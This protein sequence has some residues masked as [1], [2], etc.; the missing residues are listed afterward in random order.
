M[1]RPRK[2][3]ILRGKQRYVRKS[4]MEEKRNKEEE[5]ANKTKIIIRGKQ[6]VANNI[7]NR[8][9]TKKTKT[10]KHITATNRSW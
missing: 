3:I 7:R 1:R 6:A 9:C 5:E 4:E 8:G 2:R 10:T